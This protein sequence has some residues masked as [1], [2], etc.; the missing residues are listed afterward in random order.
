MERVIVEDRRS[1]G[2]DL[3]VHLAR[4]R[5]RSDVVVVAL[6]RGGVPVAAVI[7]EALSAPLDVLL[8]RKLGAPG[9]PELALGA[10]AAGGGRVL[11]A[12]LVAALGVT[13]REIE[14]LAAR[15]RIEL[16]R[17]DRVYR[18]GRPAVALSDRCVILVDDGIATGATVRAAIEVIRAQHPSRLVLAV[19]VAA[20]ETVR[21][22][23]ASTDE[24]V[25]LAQPEPFVAIGLWYRRFDQ[26]GDDEVIRLLELARARTRTARS[27]ATPMSQDVRIATG[28]VV[29]DGTLAVPPSPRGLVMFAHGS[30]SSRHSAR[31]LRVAAVL[32]GAGFAT[33]LFDLLTPVEQTRE[34]HGAMLRFDVALLA[35]RLGGALDWIRSH[36]SF[37]P[38]P[39][40]LFGASTGAA[41]ALTVA[42]GRAGQVAAVVSRG[43]RPDLAMPSLPQVRAP[44]LLIVG[45]HDDAVL[46]LTRSAA[47]ALACTHRVEIVPQATHLFEEPG[48]LEQVATLAE[49]W[50]VAHLAHGACGGGCGGGGHASAPS[51]PA[52]PSSPPA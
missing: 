21:E 32:N 11:N 49:Q 22:L 33:L 16:E 4:Y 50:F 38:L 46:A 30:G 20:P 41:A 14:H 12:E 34:S 36:P 23:A 15:E 28:T 29:L 51:S 19:P 31:N 27:H 10:I 52:A 39:L 18:A 47:A 6:P 44:T 48:A 40:G 9:Q 3:A 25:C 35:E 7:A 24:L 5:D 43:G 37:G 2:R 17:R 1:A 42:A 45:E 13:E 26:V 8:V